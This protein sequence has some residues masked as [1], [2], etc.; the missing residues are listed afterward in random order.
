MYTLQGYKMDFKSNISIHCFWALFV[1]LR[2]FCMNDWPILTFPN[3]KIVHILGFFS[4]DKFMTELK[5]ISYSFVYIFLHKN[6]VN[7]KAIIE[8][9]AYCWLFRISFV[10]RIYPYSTRIHETSLKL[11]NFELT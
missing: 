6:P 10:H 1:L 2:Q 3:S 4:T 5:P 7:F 8:V 11:K 9:S